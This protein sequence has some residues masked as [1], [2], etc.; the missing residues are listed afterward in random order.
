MQNDQIYSEI[1]NLVTTKDDLKQM[2]DQLDFLDAALY[3]TKVDA[4]DICLANKVSKSFSSLISK[5]ITQEDKAL[6]LKKIRENLGQIK[7]VELTLSMDPSQKL[8]DKITDLLSSSLTQKAAID[9]KIDPSIIGGAI[10]IFNGKYYDGS[11]KTKL[12][13]ILSEYE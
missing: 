3:V 4:F 13:Q 12:K 2:L 6:V 10:V 8:I 7:T 5:L 1:T 9:I 11:L